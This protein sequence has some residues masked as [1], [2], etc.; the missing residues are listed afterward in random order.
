MEIIEGITL[1]YRHPEPHA[2]FVAAV[3]MSSG[4]GADSAAVAVSHYDPGRNQSLLDAVLEIRPPFKAIEAIEAIAN[5]LRPFQIHTVYGDRIGNYY[6]GDF[7]SKGLIY[8]SEDIPRKADNYLALLPLISS[9][10]ISLIYNERLIDQLCSLSRRPMPGGYE[11]IE[12]SGTNQHDDISDCVA[13]SLYTLPPT[14]GVLQSAC[15]CHARRRQRHAIRRRIGYGLRRAAA[16]LSPTSNGTDVPWV[17]ARKSSKELNDVAATLTQISARVAALESRK[18]RSRRKPP[19]EGSS[20]QH[21]A[22]SPLDPTPPFSTVFAGEETANLRRFL[23]NPG[24]AGCVE[25]AR[26]GRFFR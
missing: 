11:K 16:R 4:L 15:A 25:V 14:P 5:F 17:S 1:I 3:D 19:V 7:A 18:R 23:S 26:G 6:S 20:R 24:A 12:A 13:L 9:H 8:C 21:I 2:A 10:S 22:D